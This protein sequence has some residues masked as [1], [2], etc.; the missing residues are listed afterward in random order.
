MQ[1]FV[2]SLTAAVLFIHAVCGCCWHH[3]HARADGT[4]V[5]RPAACC[6]HH[7]ENDRQR[8]EKPGKC[9]GEC[10]GTCTY[11]APQKVRVEPPQWESMDLLTALPSLAEGS[12]E[13]AASWDA[14]TSL[15]EPALPVRTHLMHQVLLN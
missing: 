5:K 7:H 1:A 10:E 14:L 13:K 2:A 8:H 3:A 15:L 11:L 6:H 4:L 12:I 9:K